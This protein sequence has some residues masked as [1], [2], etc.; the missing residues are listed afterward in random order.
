M[1][2]TGALAFLGVLALV[3]PCLAFSAHADRLKADRILV[4]KQDRRL[5]LFWKT[6]PVKVYKVALGAEPVGPKR[7]QGDNRTPEGTYRIDFRN[8]HSSYHRSLH[9][10]YPNREDV[11]RARELGCSPGGDI[12]IHGLPNGRGKIGALHRLYDWTAGCIAVTN[13]EIE[14]VWDAVPDGTAVEIRP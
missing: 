4:E 11:R 14:E 3:L 5:T 9:V 8:R 7:C 10:T 6:Q 12:M 1:S 2:R 13:E